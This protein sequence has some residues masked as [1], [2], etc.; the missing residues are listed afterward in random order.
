MRRLASALVGAVLAASATAQTV[1]RVNGVD[2]SAVQFNLTKR[3]VAQQAMGQQM[4]ESALLR[5]AMDQSIGLVILAQA[6]REAKITVD[7]KAVQ[8]LLDQ[9]QAQMGGPEGVQKA[10]KGLGLTEQDRKQLAEEQLLI[11][12]YVEDQIAAKVVVSDDEIKTYFDGHPQ[13]FQRPEEV[14]LWM[15]LA[16]VEPNADEKTQAAAKARAEAALKRVNSG[17]A[18]A[19]V[20]SEV[21]DDPSKAKGGEIGWIRKG[22]LL[23]ELEGPVFALAAGKTSD[24]LKS[25]FGYHVFRVEDKRPA[26]QYTLAEVKDRLNNF[27]KDEKVRESLSSFVQQRRATAKVEVL[28]PVMKAALEAPAALPAAGGAAAPVPAPQPAHGGAKPQATPKPT[29]APKRP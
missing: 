15:I 8:A 13:E 10:L 5:R 7:E 6:A 26:G 9:Q 18:F 17:E 12:R 14:K 2:V 21:S 23:P 29:D 1:M 22:L 11:Q 16:K 19:K 4:P 3:A 25:Q 27:L 28:D 20:A 24:V